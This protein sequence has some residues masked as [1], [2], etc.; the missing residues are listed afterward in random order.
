MPKQSPSVNRLLL[1]TPPGKH[2]RTMARGKGKN[3]KRSLDLSTTGDQSASAPT[4]GDEKKRRIRRKPKKIS[5]E[6]EPTLNPAA[7]FIDLTETTPVK[8]C[9]DLSNDTDTDA[10]AMPE[11]SRQAAE[12]SP[13]AKGKSRDLSFE[14]DTS[15]ASVPGYQPSSFTPM[16]SLLSS[17]HHEDDIAARDL[18]DGEVVEAGQKNLEIGHGRRKKPI[19]IDIDVQPH[20]D[21][22]VKTNEAKKGTDNKT[23]EQGDIGGLLLPEHVRLMESD[24]EGEPIEDSFIGGKDGV[25]V[26][27]DSNAKA[28]NSHLLS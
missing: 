23:I 4:S 24:E 28:S 13:N 15:F 20:L 17:M 22:E 8:D 10:D 6:V 1:P 3:R 27:D 2:C 7:D 25:H 9:I 26:V 18:E 16:K 12:R 14:N 19:L 5:L 21:D 11:S